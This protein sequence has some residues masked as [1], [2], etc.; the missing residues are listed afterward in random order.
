MLLLIGNWSEGKGEF[1]TS[2]PSG[3]S[4]V[5]T[6]HNKGSNY[7]HKKSEQRFKNPWMLLDMSSKAFLIFLN[8]VLKGENVVLSI[9][10][11]I[12]LAVKMKLCFQETFELYIFH[13]IFLLSKE[14]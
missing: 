1:S 14:V 10:F 9:T 7:A 2:A 12:L 11:G 13:H 6:L 5:K 8:N 3:P 4:K